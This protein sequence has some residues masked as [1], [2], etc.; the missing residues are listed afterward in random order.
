MLFDNLKNV[1]AIVHPTDSTPVISSL[2]ILFGLD[3]SSSLLIVLADVA[4]HE[5]N[6]IVDAVDDFFA[7]DLHAVS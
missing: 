5:C 1:D 4:L 7:F 3:K 6:V 2:I